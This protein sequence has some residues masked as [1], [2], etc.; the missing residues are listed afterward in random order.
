M[1]A[2]GPLLKGGRRAFLAFVR[3]YPAKE[4]YLQHAG[5]PPWTHFEV[6]GIEETPK[7]VFKG[8]IHNSGNAPVDGS[9]GGTRTACHDKAQSGRSK[10][11]KN[12]CWRSSRG[13]WQL[14]LAKEDDGSCNI[15]SIAGVHLMGCSKNT[16]IYIFV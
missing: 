9:E 11:E 16:Y 13:M 3:A 8:N 4:K 6:S 14:G 15:D 1:A 12:K 2:V 7:V 10:G 5:T